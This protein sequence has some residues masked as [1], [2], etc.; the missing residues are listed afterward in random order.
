MKTSE[1]LSENLNNNNNKQ[2]KLIYKT[3]CS[4]Y[5]IYSKYSDIKGLRRQ[6]EHDQTPKM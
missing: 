5:C 1:V 2:V 4:F 6:L 3:V